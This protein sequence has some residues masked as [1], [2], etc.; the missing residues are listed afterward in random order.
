MN[1]NTLNL[2][3]VVATLLA[4]LISALIGFDWTTIVSAVVA[5]K[6]VGSLNL[7]NLVIKTLVS[8]VQ[9]L[10]AKDTSTTPPTK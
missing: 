9:Q 5:L 2:I 4:T 3:A 8:S 1:T 6:I 10:A 7:L